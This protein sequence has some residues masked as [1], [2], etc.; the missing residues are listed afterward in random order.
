MRACSCTRTLQWGH[1]PQNHI[2]VG[3][4]PGF[5]ATDDVAAHILAQ[6]VTLEGAELSG[7]FVVLKYARATNLQKR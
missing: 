1:T 6:K 5:Y 7:I 4:T 3:D 2:L